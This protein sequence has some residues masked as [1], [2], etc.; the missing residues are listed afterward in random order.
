MTIV[1]FLD[2]WNQLRSVYL[3]VDGHTIIRGRKS[4]ATT[5]ND[6]EQL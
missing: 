5:L 4:F 6:G 2:A 3:V 1:I